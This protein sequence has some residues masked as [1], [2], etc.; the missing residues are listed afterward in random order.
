MRLQ[1]PH[2]VRMVR[3]PCTGKV[4]ILQLLEALLAGAD[5]VMVVG[6]MEGDCHFVSGNI[7]ARRRVERAKKILDAARIGA[8]RLEMFNL[9]ASAAPKFVEAV[10][11]MTE[12]VRALG[13]NPI[14]RGAMGP[15]GT[16]SD[17]RSRTE[18]L[19]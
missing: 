5:G 14:E 16:E 12:R 3:L 13:P 10:V 9:E 6:C 7:K 4:D 1:Y 8:D 11:E 18:E 19:G 17:D 15:R 2:N